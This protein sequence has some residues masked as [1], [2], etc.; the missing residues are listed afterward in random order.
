MG[1]VMSIDLPSAV[2]RRLLRILPEGL[3][4]FET[5]IFIACCTLPFLG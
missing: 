2:L 4:P 5:A 1:A 3:P